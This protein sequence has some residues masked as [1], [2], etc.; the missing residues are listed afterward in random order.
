MSSVF[1]A[2]SDDDKDYRTSLEKAR[3]LALKRNGEEVAY[4]PQA[5]ALLATSNHNNQSID[6]QNNI[7][8][9]S[10]KNKVVFTEL[11]EFVLGLYI[12]Q[13]ACKPEGEDV[14]M[15]DEEEKIAE[16]AGGWTEVKKTSE[17]EQ[18]PNSKDKEEI[19]PDK[20]IR[21]I[22]LGKGLARAMK[23]LKDQQTLRESLEWGGR[24]MDK[25]KSKLVGMVD[26]ETHRY[27]KD[28]GIERRDE[29]GRILTPK[30][31]FRLISHRFHGKGP[32]IRKKEK[33][34]NQ[35]K[36]E[37]KMKQMKSSDTLSLYVDTMKEAK[38]PYIVLSRHP[39]PS[40]PRYPKKG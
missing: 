14:L 38:T 32:G 36:K 40:N 37:L 1:S 17:D 18:L 9:D 16:A 31:A 33:R 23:L 28:I 27:K 12:D 15:H 20:T 21:E 22:A 19:V 35:Y 6:Y 2:Q 34:M 8:G 3:R 4:G 11:E 29:F 13:E 30:E 26:D 5:V 25:K 7:G 10:Q 24:N 39:E